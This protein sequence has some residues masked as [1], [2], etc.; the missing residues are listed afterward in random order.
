MITFKTFLLENHLFE[1]GKATQAAGTGRANKQDIE[2]A[3]KFVSR[4][5]GIAETKLRS[6]LLGSTSHTLNGIKPDSGDIDIAI[7]GAPSAHQELLQAM[8]NETGMKPVKIGGNTFSFAVPTTGDRKVQVDLMFVPSEEWARWMYHSAEDSKHKGRI[9]N[10]LLRSV[11]AH[12][13]KEGEDLIV[14]DKSGHEI[15]RVRKSLKNDDGLI[16]LFK[17]APLRK[18]GKGRTKSLAPATPKDVQAALKELG[19]DK[20]FSKSDDQTLT[21]DLVAAALFGKGV[22]A[23]DLMST[24]QVVQRILKLPNAK[25]IVID[26]IGNE[27]PME[28]VPKELRHFLKD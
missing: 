2:A 13:T 9:R 1:G 4:V 10:A 23:K 18:D 17:V 7:E 8:Q 12:S 6:N 19:I 27:M 16:R 28:E 24:E 5:T 26:A 15:I 25:Q 14:K 11:A 21:P 20:Q 22:K 3:L